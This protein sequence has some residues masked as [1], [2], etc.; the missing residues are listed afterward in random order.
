MRL[1]NSTKLT[2][3]DQIDQNRQNIRLE[4]LYH[5]KTCYTNFKLLYNLL[6]RDSV[7]KVVKFINGAIEIFTVGKNWN[8]SLKVN[9]AKSCLPVKRFIFLPL[10]ASNWPWLVFQL[11]PRGMQLFKQ[12]SKWFWTMIHLCVLHFRL[13]LKTSLLSLRWDH[14]MCLHCQCYL[15]CFSQGTRLTMHKRGLYNGRFVIIL[16]KWLLK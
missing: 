9:Q 7:W 6:L 5:H 1:T 2:V 4:D 15:R 14:T 16:L 10:L 12:S 13:L 8:L 3:I 11:Y